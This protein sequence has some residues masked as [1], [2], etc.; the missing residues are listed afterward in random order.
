MSNLITYFLF[1]QLLSPHVSLIRQGYHT[2]NYPL[3]A[4]FDVPLRKEICVFLSTYIYGRGTQST[5]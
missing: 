3:L 5:R 1:T 4:P 2:K